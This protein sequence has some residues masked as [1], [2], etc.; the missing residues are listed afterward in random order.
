M[1]Y[2]EK[3]GKLSD[4][5]ERV[6]VET[7]EVEYYNAVLRKKGEPKNRHKSYKFVYDKA[8]VQRLLAEKNTG[9]HDEWEFVQEKQTTGYEAVK[10]INLCRECFQK[11]S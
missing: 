6:P 2:C 9:G 5:F 7:R 10:E 3:C 4:W 1:N 11:E 8:E